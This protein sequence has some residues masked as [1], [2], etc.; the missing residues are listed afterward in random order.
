M[1]TPSITDDQLLSFAEG[2][3]AAAQTAEIKVYLDANPPAARL[4]A[5]YRLVRRR[6][7]EDDTMAPPEATLARAK[8]LFRRHRP[9]AVP[10]WP[11]RLVATIA[12]LVYDSRLEPV[13][14]R[15]PGLG[16]R[17]QIAAETDDLEVDLQVERLESRSRWRVT[18]QI[19]GERSLPGVE[20]AVIASGQT[21]PITVVN[22]D[23]HGFFVVEVDT[24]RYDLRF[25]LPETVVVVPDIDVR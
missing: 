3:L 9:E 1:R 15:D 19:D 8:E 2:T 17:F 22:A 20:V 6:R 14:V 13:A 25:H 23:E 24:G 11:E 4:V 10:T 5:I 16:S 18:G 21:E 12:R 7:H